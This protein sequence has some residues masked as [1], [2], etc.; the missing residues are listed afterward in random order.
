MAEQ[1]KNQEKTSYAE[2]LAA[3]IQSLKGQPSPADFDELDTPLSAELVE[4]LHRL[5]RRKET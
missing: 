3:A 4:E 2:R 5:L 1:E